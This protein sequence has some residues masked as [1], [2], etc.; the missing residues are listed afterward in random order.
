MNFRAPVL[1]LILLALFST[2]VFSQAEDSQVKLTR[3]RGMKLTNLDWSPDGNWI[4]YMSRGYIRKISPEGGKSEK[5]TFDVSKFCGQPNFTP[6]SKKITFTR[7]LDYPTVEAAEVADPYNKEIIIEN[8]LDGFWSNDGKFLVYSMHDKADGVNPV[9]LMILNVESGKSEKILDTAT[10]GRGVFSYDGTYLII[11]MFD[12]SYEL[13]LFKVPVKDGTLAGDPEQLTTGSGNHMYPSRMTADGWF[14]F[15]ERA[16]DYKTDTGLLIMH[17]FNA[18]SG[19]SKRVFPDME[20]A[21][22]YG[23]L[24]P[25]GKRVV[26]YKGTNLETNMD[27][28]VDDFPFAE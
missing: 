4:T 6:D 27:V 5:M 8:A 13:K 23:C 3:D 21:H 7:W 2:A 22:G 28:Y 19:E 17:A 20:E 10:F 14:L 11:E 25:D 9:D 24:S 18:N 16:R 12:D 1:S 26:F 15:S